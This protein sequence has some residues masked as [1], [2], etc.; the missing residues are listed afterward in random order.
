MNRTIA[1]RAAN[2]DG[3]LSGKSKKPIISGFLDLETK[4]NLKPSDMIR[5]GMLPGG[6]FYPKT[7]VPYFFLD[8]EV[9]QV[10]SLAKLDQNY[11]EIGV[12]DTRNFLLLCSIQFAR[13]SEWM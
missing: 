10:T 8:E 3:Y 9:L 13:E 12:V 11:K 4:I 7:M 2:D 1:I 6:Y 5:N